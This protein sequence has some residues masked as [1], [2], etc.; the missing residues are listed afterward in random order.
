MRINEKLK[1]KPDKVEVPREHVV[2]WLDASLF[3]TI[4]HKLNNLDHFRAV[5]LA[6]SLHFCTSVSVSGK[7]L[8]LPTVLYCT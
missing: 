1:S 3:L 7:P 5:A 8:V 2:D 4:I 6:F